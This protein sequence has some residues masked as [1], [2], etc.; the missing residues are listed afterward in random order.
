[1]AANEA[2]RLVANARA[3]ASGKCCRGNLNCSRMSAS[4]GILARMTDSDLITRLH[5]ALE[6]RYRIE[7]RLGDVSDR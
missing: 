4:P 2:V 7:G 5:A 1:M 6:G 3:N